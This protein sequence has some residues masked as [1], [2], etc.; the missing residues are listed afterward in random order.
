MDAAW[1]AGVRLERRRAALQTVEALRMHAHLNGGT[2]PKSLAEL[3]PPGVAD[4]VFNRPFVYR[5]T[6]DG[7]MQLHSDA[8]K[9]RTPKY[10][11]LHVHLRL[12]K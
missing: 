10:F 2:A 3:H 4:P 1:F 11:S 7:E 8:P 9:G 5:V 6:D 12:T